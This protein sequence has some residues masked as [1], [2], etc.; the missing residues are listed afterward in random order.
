M[1]GIRLICYRRFFLINAANVIVLA[2]VW[3][4]KLSLKG[5]SLPNG[6]DLS[7]EFGQIDSA[8]RVLDFCGQRNT[9]AR[10]YSLLI[11]DLRQQLSKSLPV[12]IADEVFPSPAAILKASQNSRPYSSSVVGHARSASTAGSPAFQDQGGTL[13]PSSIMVSPFTD[14]QFTGS[15]YTGSPYTTAGALKAGLEPWSEQFESFYTTQN[16]STFGT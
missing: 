2:A 9:F 5:D 3:K 16:P 1:K 14:S 6:C 4:R 10:K 11:K 7:L 13:D 15:P 8:I 12:N